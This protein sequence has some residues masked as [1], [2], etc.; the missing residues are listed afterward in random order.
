MSQRVFVTGGSG[1]VGRN[2]IRHLCARGDT[3]RAL[4]RTDSSAAVVE[5]LGAESVRGGLDD[6]SAMR[7]GMAGCNVIFHAAA[8]VDEWGPKQD[9]ERDNVDGTHNVITAARAAG[10]PCLVHVSTEAV[11]A[12]GRP[13][14]DAD[15]SRPRPQHP[16]PR[17][18]A[19]KAASE[20][21]VVAANE[22]ALRTVVIRPRLIWGNDDTSVAAQLETAILAGRFMWIGGGRYPTSTCH[23]DNLC[24]GLLLA[25]EKGRGGEIYFVTDGEPVELRSFITALLRARGVRVPD[26]SVPHAVALALAMVTEALWER[27]HLKGHPPATRTAV[28]LFGESVTVRDDKARREL[29]YVGHVSRDEGL[30]RLSVTPA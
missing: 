15:E 1:Y 28:R 22:P 13:I 11:L 16:L 7:V 25:A 2:L 20:A 19:T 9:F 17:Y 8:R 5:A 30:R 6:I 29:G 12:D 23:V 14:R 3:V 18:P 26:K 24:E 27:L 4:V 10:V 21:L